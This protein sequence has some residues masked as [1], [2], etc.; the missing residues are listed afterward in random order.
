MAAVADGN[1]ANY[2]WDEHDRRVRLVD[3]EDSGRNDRAFELGE[4]C[5][6][7]SRLDGPLAVQAARVLWLLG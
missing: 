2:L 3:W 4:L 1:R 7:I 6:H 5:E